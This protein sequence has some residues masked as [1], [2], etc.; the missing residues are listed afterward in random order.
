VIVAAREPSLPPSSRILP[1]QPVSTSHSTPFRPCGYS[2]ARPPL[3]AG[4]AVALGRGDLTPGERR[5]CS[6]GEFTAALL[7]RR[8]GLRPAVPNHP[9]AQARTSS[10]TI[11]A[12]TLVPQGSGPR[13]HRPR[14]SDC[15]ARRGCV[16]INGCVP[17]NSA[18]SPRT[19]RARRRAASRNGGPLPPF[20]RIDA[21][22][23]QD[24]APSRADWRTRGRGCLPRLDR[25]A[26]ARLYL[27]TA[28]MR[29]FPHM[30]RRR[31]LGLAATAAAMPSLRPLPLRP[32]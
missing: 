10:T 14:P 25:R 27:R 6:P 32:R 17:I 1:Q 30:S 20:T 13:V 16:L 2:A 18:A 3:P 26:T 19:S 4:P 23:I 11:T 12:P 24:W 9:A 28:S 7:R 31:L 15:A 21:R 5:A 8:R 22:M 29:A